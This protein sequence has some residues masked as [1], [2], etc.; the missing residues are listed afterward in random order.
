[1][2]SRFVLQMEVVRIALENC[3]L[4]LGRARSRLSNWRPP[5]KGSSSNDGESLCSLVDSAREALQQAANSADGF[6][7]TSLSSLARL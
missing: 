5:D 1:M 3:S 7:S 2:Y 4:A 6:V